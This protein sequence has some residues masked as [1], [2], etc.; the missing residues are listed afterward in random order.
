[1]DKKKI[2]AVL[3]VIL[4]II[5]TIGLRILNIDTAFWYDEACSW[6]SAKQEFPVGIINNLLQLDLQHTPLYFFLLHFWM[7]L[8]G[9]SE[10]AIRSL[11]MIFG[12]GTVPLVYIVAKK[13]ASKAVGVMATFV[14]AVSPLL[15][16]FSV[17]ARMYPIVVF[18]VMLSLNYLIDFEQNN[19]KKSL[20]KLFTVNLLIPYTL[21]GGILYNI[22]LMICYGIYLF[23]SK[24][25]KFLCY[26]R[27]VG[28]EFICLIPY[29]AMV[30]YYAG[31]RR[32]FVIKHEGEMVFANVIDMIRNFFGVSISDNIY[33]PSSEPYAM[34]FLVFLLIFV[35]CT[36][37]VYGLVQGSKESKGFLKCLYSVFFLSL[38]FSIVL[39][40]FEVNVFTV[41]YILYL[42]PPM[43]ILSI[44]GLSNRISNI[45]LKLFISFF[46]IASCVTN[47]SYSQFA[48]VVKENAFK[49]V[50]IEAKNLQLGAD[51]LVIMPFGA[52]AP[53]Y[54]KT[55][56]TPRVYD[57]D[58]H[59]EVRNPY[60]SKFYDESQQ[61][62]MDKK[63]RYG[64]IFD[65]IFADEGFSQNHKD[66]FMKNVNNTV[67]KGRYVLM[68]LYST[69]FHSVVTLEDL[70]KSVTSIQDVKYN[71]LSLLLKKYLYDIRAY[72]DQDFN[73]LGDFT[74]DSYTY[75]LFQKR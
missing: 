68:A 74:K 65:R 51:D 24:R 52:D 35:P 10:I 75:M 32:L 50:M 15:V 29:F 43:F 48:K 69:D 26:L 23:Y 2:L 61:K 31:M 4:L 34:T 33:W 16:F 11:S 25:D 59:K 72:L 19:D 63:A 46:V 38:L 56:D 41:R 5:V 27:E 28:G 73:Y 42:L 17:E 21:V 3:L 7:K 39:S 71:T 54:F 55:L 47:V 67:P 53:Y 37:F 1:M 66:Y 49:A 18:L 14:A 64:V 58:F 57:F 36:Y 40:Y 8:F 45:H 70:R 13:L 20:F 60:N 9:N 6:V 62:L 30:F 12:V 44:I 22:S